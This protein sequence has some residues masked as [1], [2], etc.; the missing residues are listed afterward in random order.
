MA[1]QA[2]P[3]QLLAVFHALPAQPLA[4]DTALERAAVGP[5]EV[6]A[7]ANVT[8]QA[9]LRSGVLHRDGRRALYPYSQS[10]E[11]A[12]RMFH[13]RGFITLVR[14]SPFGVP[15]EI[16]AEPAASCP[17]GAGDQGVKRQR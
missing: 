15:S 5:D 3:P 17:A 14:L 10:F 1:P 9:W 11:H 6:Y 8:L 7:G 2:L 16:S 12:D 4:V 13:R